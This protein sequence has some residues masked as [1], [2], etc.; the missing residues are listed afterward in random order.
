MY[1]AE[2]AISN[3]ECGNTTETEAAFAGNRRLK[4]RSH[5]PSA[6]LEPGRPDMTTEVNSTQTAVV[7][8]SETQLELKY[9]EIAYLR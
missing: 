8:R 6:N 9:S 3:N 5:L 7:G 2:V 1:V 4:H